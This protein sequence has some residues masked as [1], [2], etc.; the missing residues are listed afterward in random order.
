MVRGVKPTLECGGG[1]ENG[2]RHA[3]TEPRVTTM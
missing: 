1:T 3:D 2:H